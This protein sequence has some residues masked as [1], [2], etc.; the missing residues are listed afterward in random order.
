MSQDHALNV[1][2]WRQLEGKRLC[3][4]ELV[5]RNGSPDLNID[6]PHDLSAAERGLLIEVLRK[7]PGMIEDFYEGRAMAGLHA[8]IAHGQA[9]TVVR[10]IP[11]FAPDVA[12]DLKEQMDRFDHNLRRIRGG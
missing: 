6:L 7:I 1:A 5:H 3:L 2:N 9:Q 12:D 11:L 4:F 10:D 8:D